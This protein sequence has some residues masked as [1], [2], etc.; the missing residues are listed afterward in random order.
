MGNASF[1]SQVIG[2]QYAE[3]LFYIF[4]VLLIIIKY[5]FRLTAHGQ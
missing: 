2:A 1:M 4:D 5:D 3:M